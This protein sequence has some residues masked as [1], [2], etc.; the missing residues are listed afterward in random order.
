MSNCGVSW[1]AKKTEPRTGTYRSV[2]NSAASTQPRKLKKCR[3]F[4]PNFLV[5]KSHLHRKWGRSIAISSQ[6]NQHEKWNIPGDIIVEANSNIFSTNLGLVMS[7][8][9]QV[10]FTTSLNFRLIIVINWN[11]VSTF[12]GMMNNTTWE[13]C[14]WAFIRIITLQDF[15]YRLN[16]WNH[17][18]L[19]KG[20]CYLHEKVVTEYWGNIFFI[21]SWT[22]NEIMFANYCTAYNVKST[23]KGY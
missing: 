19:C 10:F 15:T 23:H 4:L 16:T 3:C 14:F 1:L 12:S 9:R 2:K 18:V 20:K 5:M 17:L 7:Q 13:H 21:W 6:F 22:S 8:L 11:E